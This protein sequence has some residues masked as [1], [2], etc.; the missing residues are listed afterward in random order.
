MI[1]TI[2][3]TEVLGGINK[4][5]FS[6]LIEIR[7]RVNSPATISLGGKYFL[8]GEEG[9]VYDEEKAIY[10]SKEMIE[11]FI[12]RAS[13]NSIYA[14]NSQIQQGY[15]TISGGVRIGICGNLVVE[16][17]KIITINNFS[18]VSI[19]IPHEIKNC[20]LSVL[21]FLF[22]SAGFKNTLIISPPGAGKTT[23]IRDIACQLSNLNIAYNLLIL[24]ER[25]EIASCVNGQPLL[26]VGKFTD[27]LSGANKRFGFEVGTRG[28]RPDIIFTDELAT[29]QDVDAVLNASNC[30]VKIVATAHAQNITQFRKKTEF[31]ELFSSKTFE[32]YILLSSELGPGTID[33][34]F[35]EKFNCIFCRWNMIVLLIVLIVGACAFVGWQV[36]NFYRAR[37]KFFEDQV[38]FCDILLSETNFNKTPLRH[39]IK[40]NEA[41]FHKDFLK[42]LTAFQNALNNGDDYLEKSL[43]LKTFEKEEYNRF[44]SSLGKTDLENHNNLINNF[45]KS[46]LMKIERE[47]NAEQKK[48]NAFFKISICIGLAIAIICV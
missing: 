18:S 15:I 17:G 42:S 10:I 6:K 20:S 34:I 14:V 13:E 21:K 41:Q 23:F 47:V 9:V 32:R 25:F 3:P 44:L 5:D 19:R 46:I 16:N 39:I 7:L 31:D 24:D 36:K 22:D 4:V 27:V 45:K 11:K 1:K 12:F 43:L 48:A 38:L 40:K 29:K 28:L 33:G 30:G 35:D 37:Q 2:L 8:L 26:N